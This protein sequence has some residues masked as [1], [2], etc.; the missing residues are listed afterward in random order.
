MIPVATNHRRLLQFKW[1]GET[2]QFNCLPFGLSSAPWVFTN[3]T[4]VIVAIF[5]TTDQILWLYSGLHNNGDQTTRGEKQENKDGNHETE[6]PGQPSSHSPVKTTGQTQ[7]CHTSNPTCSSVLLQLTVLLTRSPG[8]GRPRPCDAGQTNTGM[9]RGKAIT[10]GRCKGWGATC[11]G[12]WTGGPWSE[13]ESHLHIN[14]LELL[15]VTLAVKCFARDKENIV[16]LL[17][18]D[19]TTAIAYINKLG[20]TVSPELNH[21]ETKKML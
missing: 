12:V 17:T 5:R 21:P 6:T 14:C 10:S 19:K 8:G 4:K 16:I 13:T 11:E 18:M 2:Y 20:G 15:A 7:S 3:T 9:H 1:L